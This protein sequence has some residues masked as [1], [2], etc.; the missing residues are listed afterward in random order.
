MRLQPLCNKG[1]FFNSSISHNDGTYVKLYICKELEFIKYMDL[2]WGEIQIR[3]FLLHIHM[4]T[5]SNNYK[6]SLSETWIGGY[7]F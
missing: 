2:K 4:L 5:V 7:N 3:L 6:I 1:R